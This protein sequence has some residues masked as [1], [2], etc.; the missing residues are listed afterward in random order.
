VNIYE[1][2]QI[3]TAT[4][5]E[6]IEG[7][8]RA[9]GLHLESGP[10]LG[11]SESIFQV[12]L[13]LARTMNRPIGLVVMMLAT[14]MSVDVMGF[15]IPTKG[16]DGD[17][18]SVFSIP[19]WFPAK[20]NTYVVEPD[21]TWHKPGTWTGDVPEFGILFLDEFSQADEDVKKPS[22]E[23]VLNG[24]VGNRF[25]PAG[26]RVISAGNRTTD[27]SG[28][29]RELMHI[30]NRRARLK[31]VPSLPAWLAWARAQPDAT[32]P[33]YMTI[34]FAEQ[35]P[36]VVFKDAIPAGSEPYCTPRSLVRMDRDI[37]A[38]RTPQDRK[39]DRM[40]MNDLALEYCASWVGDGDAGQYMAH[41][42][43][44][45]LIPTVGEIVADPQA[46]KLPPARDGQMVA[47]Y[48]LAHHV[49][50]DNAGPLFRYLTRL[51][52]EMQVL[53]VRATQTDPKRQAAMMAAPGFTQWLSANK[54]LLLASH[55]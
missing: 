42:K 34:A 21:G 3:I 47:G 19:P 14:V 20:S 23:L 53:A 27:R 11:K 36:D 39:D 22:A 55:S 29:M 15:M 44:A 12:A 24:N 5:L 17:I 31:L 26:W 35:H 8:Y 51:A 9:S 10:G 50:E 54:E 49:D 46:A 28:V 48:M 41:L 43:Y 25:L 13:E 40:P 4:H 52:V 38:L 37:R 30:I 7:G 32:R 1:A 16:A 45:D 18:N 2:K 33:H 6:A